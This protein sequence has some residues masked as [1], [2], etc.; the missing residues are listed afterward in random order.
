MWEKIIKVS[1]IEYHIFM[2]SEP[3]LTITNSFV[4][5]YPLNPEGFDEV[6]NSHNVNTIK[7]HWA[8]IDCR[9]DGM[10]ITSD[11]LAGF[12][13]YYLINED[14]LYVSD[15]FDFLVEVLRHECTSNTHEFEYWKKHRF[16]TG[17]NTILKQIK[18]ILAFY[19]FLFRF[20]DLTIRNSS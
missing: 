4:F 18:K 15:Q 1:G 8:K 2:S 19:T 9:H 6:D 17:G 12:K 20:I 3:V 10:S 7:G 13:I 5:G 11:I 14:K 16:T